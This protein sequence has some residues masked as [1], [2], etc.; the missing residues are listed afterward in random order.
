VCLETFRFL[1][2]GFWDVCEGCQ[3]SIQL[4]GAYDTRQTI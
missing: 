3:E 4:S 2:L 1:N